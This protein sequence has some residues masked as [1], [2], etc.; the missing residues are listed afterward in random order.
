M[1]FNIMKSTEEKANS[2]RLYHTTVDFKDADYKIVF[3]QN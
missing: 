3:T 2:L 1:L